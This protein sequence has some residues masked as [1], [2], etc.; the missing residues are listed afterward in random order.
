MWATARVM[1]HTSEL[2]LVVVVACLVS[3]RYDRSA[4]AQTVHHHRHQRRP[5]LS[6]GDKTDQSG[7][8]RLPTAARPPKVFT[9]TTLTSSTEEARFFVDDAEDARAIF[10]VL[11]NLSSKVVPRRC[12]ARF[13]YG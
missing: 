7:G 4:R 8:G 5:S 12:S 2:V 6:G 1:R 10:L 11:A 3:L 9:V 13:A